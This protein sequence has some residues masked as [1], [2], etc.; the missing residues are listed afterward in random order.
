MTNPEI[1]I[2]D[3]KDTDYESVLKLNTEFSDFFEEFDKWQKKDQDTEAVAKYYLEKNLDLV[4]NNDG[5]M[6]VAESEAQV[7]GFAGAYIREQTE[8]EALTTI[9]MRLGHLETLF[10]SQQFRNLS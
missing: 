7:V 8:E 9:P 10:V 6:F 5:A 3:Y 2:R 4:K 1:S